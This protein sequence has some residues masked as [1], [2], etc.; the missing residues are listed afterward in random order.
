MKVR[1]L[2]ER[3]AAHLPLADVVHRSRTEGQ[4]DVLHFAGL[5]Q[6]VTVAPLLLQFGLDGGDFLLELG[7]LSAR[8]GD[9]LST[10]WAE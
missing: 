7:Q 9:I 4:P 2:H 10:K 5:Q 8:D 1:D 3:V 6:V